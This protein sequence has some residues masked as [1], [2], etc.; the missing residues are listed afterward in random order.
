LWGC[1]GNLAARFLAEPR[2]IITNAPTGI[3]GQCQ[4][5][6][7][8]PDTGLIDGPGLLGIVGFHPRFPY[9]FPVEA[10]VHL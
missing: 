7:Y 4:Y 5:W 8:Y 9:G 2:L 1:G 6:F 10:I 3:S